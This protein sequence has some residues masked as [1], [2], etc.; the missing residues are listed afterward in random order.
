MKPF[1]WPLL[2][3]FA[4][5]GGVP[6]AHAQTVDADN[7]ALIQQ[8]P[9]AQVDAWLKEEIRRSGGDLEHQ[10]Y[11]FLIGFSTGHYNTDPVHAIAMRR[12]AFSL[13]NNTLA[14]GDRVTA[15]AWEMRLWGIGQTVALKDDT[16]SRAAFVD[17]VAY[18]PM[19]GSRGGHDTERAL[20]DALTRVVPKGEEKSAVILLL[21][22]T[23]Q[24]QSPTGS[25]ESLFG[26]NNRRLVEAIQKGG[27]RTPPVRHTFTLRAKDRTLTVD[28]TALFPRQIE[29]LPGAP[30]T[31]RYPTFARETWQPPAD[32]PAPE[33]PLPNPVASVQS[34]GVSGAE[35]S[36]TASP[37]AQRRGAPPW[38][39]LLLAL[40][41]IAVAAY[42]LT[43]KPKPA[44]AKERA[45]EPKPVPAGRP[46][47]GALKASVG[48]QE[49]DLK[50][51][52]T[53]SRWELVRRGDAV[54]LEPLPSLPDL[55]TPEHPNTR[56]P[57]TAPPTPIPEGTVLA[58]LSFDE[59][60]RLRVE[61]SG[62]TQ[63]VEI[64][65]ATLKDS[66]NRLLHLAP[67]ERM[68]C[69]LISADSSARVRL[70]LHYQKA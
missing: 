40:I 22:N 25:R 61:A 50:P 56:T 31:P 41:V 44:P 2:I 32:R 10:R 42:L 51:L 46:L 21:T 14:A 67:G 68:F 24:S 62:D 27:F 18:A 33:E 60:G 45:D 6:R 43:R 59:R 15:L 38:T 65:P 3:C 36:A 8:V 58:S 54:S 48:A 53:A 4:V 55:S 23:N 30:T 66:T 17:S 34:A 29:S 9:R 16:A 7:Y 5:P 64:Q 37:Q 47:P 70:E 35:S 49:V 26:A 69:R 52:T 11:H 13:L 28:V 12:L 63:F 1:L 57:D 20:Y 19:Q 39:L